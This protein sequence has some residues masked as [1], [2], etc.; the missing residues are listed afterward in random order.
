[1][2]PDIQEAKQLLPL[3]ALMAE[4]GYGDRAKKSARCPF[5][6]DHNPSFGIFEKDGHWFFKCHAG[7]G[8]GDEI[9]FIQKA[10]NIDKSAA[11]RHYKEL[12]GVSEPLTT[13]ANRDA[14]KPRNER[15]HHTTSVSTATAQPVIGPPEIAFEERILDRFREA[16]R[17]CGVVGEEA[18]AATLYLLITT[19]LLDK[20]VSAAVKGLSSS[21]KSF[22]TEKTVEFFP[23]AAVIVMT[24]MSERALVYSDQEYAH[25]TLILYEATALR[26]GAEDNLTAYFVRSLLSEGRIE[27]PVTVPNPKDGSF[28][29]KTIVKEG[30]TNLIVTTTKTRVHAENETRLLSL[31]TNDTPAQTKAIFRALASEQS[32]DVDKSEWRQL[33]VWLQTA[34]HRVTIPYATALAD[35]VPPVAVRLRRDFGAVLALIKAHAI[36]HQLSR[37]RDAKGRIIATIDDYGDVRDLVAPIMSE[38]VG[39]TVSSVVRDT[40]E[41]VAAIADESGVMAVAIADQLKLDKGTVSRRLR[42]TAEAGFIRNLEDRRGKPGRWVTGDPLPSEIDPLPPPSDLYSL[43]NAGCTVASDFKGGYTQQGKVTV[44]GQDYDWSD[45]VRA[46]EFAGEPD[47]PGEQSEE[48]YNGDG[49]NTDDPF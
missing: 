44:S 14:G 16:I 17:I 22:T 43:S 47:Y 6:D 35:L 9:D 31:N 37:E 10:L 46:P 13:Q 32:E 12:A 23:P 7:C 8:A 1:M 29:T 41:A 36:L 45:C 5:H 26:E 27:Y 21:G 19:R 25:R 3:A 20:P 15:Q 18:I 38:T 28:T 40:V 49:A 39:A 48:A 24:A 4:L 34:E 33:Q 30:P 2:R 42:M 11:I